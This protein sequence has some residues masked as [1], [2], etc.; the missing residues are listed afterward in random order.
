MFKKKTVLI[1][2]A[3]ASVP[4]HYPTGAE[5]V[6]EVKTAAKN[7]MPAENTE[8]F[9]RN[10]PSIERLRNF[11]NDIKRYN[12]INIDYFLHQLYGDHEQKQDETKQEMLKLGRH[13]IAEII[14]KAEKRNDGNYGGQ[15]NWYRFLRHDLL[16]DRALEGEKGDNGLPEA[17]NRSLDNLKIITFNYDVSLEYYL[18]DTLSQVLDEAGAQAVLDKLDILHV[19]GQVRGDDLP[20]TIAGYGNLKNNDQIH[21]YAKEVAPRIRVIGEDKS[22]DEEIKEKAKKML[23]DAETLAFFGFGFDENN[24]KALGFARDFAGHPMNWD[25]APIYSQEKPPTFNGPKMNNPS[26]T[27]PTIL[28]T[29]YDDRRK[30]HAAIEK[31]FGLHHNLG[32]QTTVLKSTGSVAKALADDFDLL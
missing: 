19:Y 15:Q 14:L 8:T 21:D 22:R 25:Y 17:L 32:K 7:R 27:N 6:E 29:N 16:S 9:Q 10:P 26:R 3:G 12:P 13:L 4:Y 28:Y 18:Y 2:G 1:L 31:L 11:I 30:V 5:L 20:L 24:L 23:R